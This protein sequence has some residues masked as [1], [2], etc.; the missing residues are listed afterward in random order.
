VAELGGH[1]DALPALLAL[2]GFPEPLF[3]GSERFARRWA[4]AYRERLLR[5]EVASLENV[6]DL[7]RLELLAPALPERVSSPLSRR[8]K[9]CR[10]RTRRSLA[11]PTCS[12]VSTA[13][14]A[15]RPSARRGCAR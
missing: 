7:G 15:C 10:S 6:S 4:L 9:T 12:N 8:A 14:S 5:E 11:G 1:A 3:N 2:G 13:S